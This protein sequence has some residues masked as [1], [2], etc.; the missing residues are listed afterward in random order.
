MDEISLW[1]FDRK[2]TLIE[3]PL[4]SSKSSKDSVF[5]VK[6][7]S[8][9]IEEVSDHQQ[10][11]MSLESAPFSFLLKG[12]IQQWTDRLTSLAMILTQFSFVQQKWIQLTPVFANDALPMF[13]TQFKK[14]NLHFKTLLNHIQV[15]L[16]Y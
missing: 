10:M 14:P 9:L 11:T 16:Y 1:S 15:P 7:W 5:I 12:E 3:A 6:D 2:F 13:Q 8:K 4:G